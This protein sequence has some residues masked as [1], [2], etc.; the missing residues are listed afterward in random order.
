MYEPQAAP[1]RPSVNAGRLWSGGLATALVAGLISVVGI[2]LTRGLFDVPVL[3]PKGEGVWG[4]ANTFWYAFG[5]ACAA[6]VATG[7]MHVLLLTTPRPM[8]FFAWA[9]GLAT[10]AGM[11]APYMVEAE[12]ASRVCTSILNLVI[13]A[14][15]GS[16]LAG[17]ARAA[18]QPPAPRV[19]PVPRAYP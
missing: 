1:Q 6:L 19:R 18:L 15:I 11:L 16:L 12:T 14:A 4:S 2:L 17:T 8:L 5:A 3:A 7:L 9:I 13:G 10:L